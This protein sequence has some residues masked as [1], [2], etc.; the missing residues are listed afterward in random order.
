MGRAQS[1]TWLVIVLS[2]L[3]IAPALGAG[4]DGKWNFV[5]RSGEGEHNRLIELSVRGENVTAK[6]G[7]E[8]YKGTYHDGTLEITGEHFAMEAGYK[9][10]LKLSGKPAGDKIEGTASWG[11]YQL[12]FTATRAE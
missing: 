11:D 8:V 4:L 6:H 5:F 7:E 3:L 1:T 10:T 9:A 12:T 2:F